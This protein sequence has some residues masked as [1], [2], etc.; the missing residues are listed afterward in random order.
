LKNELNFYNGYS[1]ELEGG[2]YLPKS[3]DFRDV[4]KE[5]LEIEIKMINNL[6]KKYYD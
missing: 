2:M 4:E 6:R 1:R 5:K 3:T